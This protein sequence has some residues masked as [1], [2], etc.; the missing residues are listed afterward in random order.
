MELTVPKVNKENQVKMV[1]KE[2][3]ERTEHPESR[4]TKE[5]LVSRAQAVQLVSPVI[6]EML[7]HLETRDH[8]EKKGHKETK[9]QLE[10]R[11][12]WE[13]R[14]LRGNL[15]QKE[16]P[17]HLDLMVYRDHLVWM[18]LKKLVQEIRVNLESLV[19][20]EKTDQRATKDHQTQTEKRET[21]D[22]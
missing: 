21:R 8:K 20:L 12:L 7:G 3:M 10:T 22:Q 19:H 9:E 6:T 17:A 15:E 14:V 16:T 1:L 13:A 18:L 4:E 2:K 5:N 11:D